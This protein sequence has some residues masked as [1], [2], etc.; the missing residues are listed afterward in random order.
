MN[1]AGCT[2][3]ALPAYQPDDQPRHD[4]ATSPQIHDRPLPHSRRKI[5]RNF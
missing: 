3:T 2:A 1:N 4:R 5:L